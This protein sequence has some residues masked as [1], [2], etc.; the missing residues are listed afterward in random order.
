MFRHNPFLHSVSSQHRFTFCSPSCDLNDK[1]WS[2]AYQNSPISTPFAFGS[3]K[4][5]AV[6]SFS[7]FLV[8]S[9][10]YRLNRYGNRMHPWH[11]FL[12]KV[13]IF[14]LKTNFNHPFHRSLC[15]TCNEMP[16]S[17]QWSICRTLYLHHGTFVAEYSNWKYD[18]WY[19][20]HCKSGPVCSSLQ[21]LVFLPFLKKNKNSIRSLMHA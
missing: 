8:M 14:L 13:T 3:W 12:I 18:F 21:L 9:S 4:S 2:S 11:R 5:P 19:L 20:S 7:T 17:S 6:K 15:F 10:V 16:L 1:P